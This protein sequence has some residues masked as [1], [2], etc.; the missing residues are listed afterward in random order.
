VLYIAAYA[1]V[2]FAVVWWLG[3][4]VDELIAEIFKR[5]F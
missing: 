3:T 1:A 5:L 2:P 4:P